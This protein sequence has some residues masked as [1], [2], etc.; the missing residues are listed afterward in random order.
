MVKIT[1]LDKDTPW[2][3]IRQIQPC[4]FQNAVG[5]NKCHYIVIVSICHVLQTMPD[6]KICFEAGAFDEAC[7]K[8]CVGASAKLLL[9]QDVACVQQ[10]VLMTQAAALDGFRPVGVDAE[11]DVVVDECA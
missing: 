11:F 1:G 10:M 3:I 6:L 7:R 9:A 5:F 8:C 2:W 4:R